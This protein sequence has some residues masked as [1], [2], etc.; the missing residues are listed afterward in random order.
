[1]RIADGQTGCPYYLI[2]VTIGASIGHTL[3]WTGTEAHGVGK[4]VSTE[5]VIVIGEV[6]IDPGIERV[7]VIGQIADRGVIVTDCACLIE[8]LRRVKIHELHC[9]EV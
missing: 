2:T 4:A 6:M 5:N 9:I 1:M 7:S 3:K 8:V